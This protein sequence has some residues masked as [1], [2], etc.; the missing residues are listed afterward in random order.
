M[1][2]YIEGDTFAE[3]YEQLLAMCLNDPDA[4]CRPRGMEIRELISPTIRVLDPVA[5]FYTSSPRSTPMRY[6][7]GEF[8]WYFGLRDDA[9][10]ITKYSA[11][12]NKL[13]NET[14]AGPLNE[15]KLNS[16][17][18]TLTMGDAWK[19]A[20]W[21]NR[22]VT[23][24]EWALR[25]IQRDPDS[26][27]AIIHVN[28]PSHQVQWIKDF[29]CTILFQFLV[30]NG[31][32]NMVVTMRSND[33]IKG[34]TFDFPMFS[35][36]LEQFTADLA[37]MTGN[38][39]GRGHLTLTSGS[40]HIY[41]ADFDLVEGMLAAGISTMEPAEP[42]VEPPHVL[43]IENDGS[44]RRVASSSFKDLMDHAEGNHV[45]R[46]GYFGCGVFEAFRTALDRGKE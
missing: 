21:D 18:G 44:I 19:D 31:A 41:G 27:Q 38:R 17:Y 4:T 23:Q 25:S 5:R 26:R 12:W 32:V 8:L 43:S 30:R 13:K 10:F 11:F 35:L 28:R 14:S 20:S 24:W 15:G 33:L 36:F 3:V 45:L 2:A 6:A 22:W 1:S 46:P 16:S 42:L 39:Y 40:S 7:A 34:L 9:E 37:A 29:P